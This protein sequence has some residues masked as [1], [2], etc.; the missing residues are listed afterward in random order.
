MTSR[1][2]GPPDGPRTFAVPA[3]RTLR[4]LRRTLA[5]GGMPA[6]ERRAP[7]DWTRLAALRTISALLR[8]FEQYRRAVE[9]GERC[10]IVAHEHPAEPRRLLVELAIEADT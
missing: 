10:R 9:E 7:E 8:V 1:R 6:P 4:E 5:D 3:L 2:S